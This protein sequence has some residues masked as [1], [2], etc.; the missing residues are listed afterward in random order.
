L[1]SA[2]RNVTVERRP[3]KRIFSSTRLWW[4]GIVAFY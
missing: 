3:Q 4:C 2:L 1:Y